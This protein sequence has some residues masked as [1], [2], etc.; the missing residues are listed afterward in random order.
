MAALLRDASM[1]LWGTFTADFGQMTTEYLHERTMFRC[2]PCS[3][4]IEQRS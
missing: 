4:S 1:V 2:D 3:R